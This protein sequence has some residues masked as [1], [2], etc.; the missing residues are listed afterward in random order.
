MNMVPRSWPDNLERNGSLYAWPPGQRKLTLG[1]PTSVRKL[2]LAPSTQSPQQPILPS[3]NLLHPRRNYHGEHA[4]QDS[5]MKSSSM[6]TRGC[7]QNLATNV[8]TICRPMRNPLR[9]QTNNHIRSEA[10]QQSGLVCLKSRSLDATRLTPG[11][12][13]SGPCAA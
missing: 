2:S 9:R 4:S 10:I 11:R 13:Y 3:E 5:W 7:L 1:S 6:E 8:P 12:S